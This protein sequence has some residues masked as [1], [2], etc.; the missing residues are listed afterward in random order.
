MNDGGKGS[1]QRPTDH[2]AYS[3]NYD[4]IFGKKGE[5]DRDIEFTNNLLKSFEEIREEAMKAAAKVLNV[6]KD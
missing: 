3:D 4:K 6:A 2:K 1:A 5:W